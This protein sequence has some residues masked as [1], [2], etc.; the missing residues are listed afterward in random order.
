VSFTPALVCKVQEQFRGCFV[1]AYAGRSD[2]VVDMVLH[3]EADICVSATFPDDVEVFRAIPIMHEQ[4]ILVTAKGL[5]HRNEDILGQL[6][7][8]PF[9][10]YSD[11][12]PIGRTIKQHMPRPRL[13]RSRLEDGDSNQC[14]DT[15]NR[16]FVKRLKRWCRTTAI[17]ARPPSSNTPEIWTVGPAPL[18][19]R[20]KKQTL[21]SQVSEAEKKDIRCAYTQVKRFAEAPKK[22][23]TEFST[24]TEPG[25]I[26]GQRIIPVS[27]PDVMFQA[28]DTRIFRLQS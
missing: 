9:V 1:S 8:T 2:Q 13:K 15:E 5:L 22:S 18:Y 10:Q 14:M 6:H 7:K 3:N 11:S 24:E 28:G 20:K 27:W 23:L 12:V 17:P 4:F 25:V 21:I 26:P 19:C 16:K